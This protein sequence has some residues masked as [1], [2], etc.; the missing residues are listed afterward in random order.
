MQES[1]SLWKDLDLVMVQ[2]TTGSLE[3]SE[4]FRRIARGRAYARMYRTALEE[5][6]YNL[7]L[8]DFAFLQFNYTPLRAGYGVRYAYYPNPF[9]GLTYTEFQESL[10][11][12]FDQ[13]EMHEAFV[14]YLGEQQ[15]HYAAPPIRYDIAFAEYRELTHPCAH[16]HFGTH[17]DNRWP[18]AIELTPLAFSFLIAKMFYPREW[19]QAGA[20]RA[21]DEPHPFDIAFIA[22]KKACP[23]LTKEYFSVREK[24]QLYFA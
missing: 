21:A 10:G 18:V 16:F 1:T 24:A 3:V 11:E 7:L 17:R 15:P 5:R 2:R 20:A 4:S 13:E 19:K 23:S 9:S 22:A 6:A 8:T 12:G 14:Q